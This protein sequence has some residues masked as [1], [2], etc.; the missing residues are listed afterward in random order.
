MNKQSFRIRNTG[1][2]MFL[3]RLFG[4]YDVINDVIVN[5]P[6]YLHVQVIWHTA[7]CLWEKSERSKI[8]FFVLKHIFDMS[9]M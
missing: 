2:I 5:V 3:A 8:V 4:C 7:L 6:Y 9:I 1:T